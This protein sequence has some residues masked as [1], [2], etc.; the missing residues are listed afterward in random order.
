MINP[1]DGDNIAAGSGVGED[2]FS[3]RLS[4]LPCD[5]YHYG[6]VDIILE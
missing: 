4:S 1:E 3:T 6:G 5:W 2:G